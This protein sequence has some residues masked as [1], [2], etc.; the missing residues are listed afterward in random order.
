MVN[1]QSS[2]ISRQSSGDTR[3][4]RTESSALFWVLVSVSVPLFL[5]S[6]PP[7][8]PHLCL[9]PS[10]PRKE[11]NEEG[12]F[13]SG[14][15]VTNGSVRTVAPRHRSYGGPSGP[16]PIIN[17]SIRQLINSSSSLQF[18]I[19]SS[20]HHRPKTSLPFLGQST[21]SKNNPF[22]EADVSCGREG[23]HPQ[24]FTALEPNPS[25]ATP[26]YPT[27]RA[28]APWR[29]NVAEKTVSGADQIGVCASIIAAPTPQYQPSPVSQ[30]H[31]PVTYC[32]SPSQE[33]LPFTSNRPPFPT[34]Y[35]HRYY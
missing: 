23:H 33:L 24:N 31:I 16:S 25:L 29:L 9:P 34:S 19:S 30:H 15:Q 5:P 14:G 32:R 22:R 26:S 28:E 2:T 4:L 13:R 18:I 35:P 21:A 7:S 1:N 12:R 11:G 27:D 20:H 6:S 17:S 8:P 10:K 3:I